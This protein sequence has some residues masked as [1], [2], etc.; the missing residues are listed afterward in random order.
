MM[1]VTIPI[2]LAPL[3]I[4]AG[5]LGWTALAAEKKPALSFR[6]QGLHKDNNEGCAVGDLNNDG[7]LDIVAGEN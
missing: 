2:C 3:L 5:I 4:P 7:K 1:K 6:V